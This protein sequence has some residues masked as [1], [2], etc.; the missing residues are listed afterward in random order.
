MMRIGVDIG[1][2]HIGIGLVDDNGIVVQKIEKNVSL[3]NE[4]NK[5][6]LIIDTIVNGCLTVGVARCATRKI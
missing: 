2:S 3:I 4:P 1:G 5:E 6:E